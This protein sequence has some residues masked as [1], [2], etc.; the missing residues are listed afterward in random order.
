M[1]VRPSH[2]GRG[3]GFVPPWS[4]SAER[5]SESP[6]QGGGERSEREGQEAQEE[7]ISEVQAARMM[8]AKMGPAMLRA[9]SG[10]MLRGRRVTRKRACPF[11]RQPM[12]ETLNVY[13]RS[14]VD[15]LAELENESG[16]LRAVARASDAGWRTVFKDRL[17][18]TR[19]RKTRGS[20][21][22]I[23]NWRRR[24]IES[25]ATL[26]RWLD[27]YG[28]ARRCIGRKLSQEKGK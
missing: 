22:W 3:A 21:A 2:A 17:E 26:D 18:T 19:R 4:P 5:V 23:E 10:R 1:S 7:W 28:G 16:I 11:C 24:M 6:P 20:E 27:Q 9:L 13:A 14:D 15:R 12:S 25:Q 8:P